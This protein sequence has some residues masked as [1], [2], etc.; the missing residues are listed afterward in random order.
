MNIKAKRKR[1]NRPKKVYSSFLKIQVN[2][3]D[4]QGEFKILTEKIN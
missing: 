4:E 2:E 3:S 1:I